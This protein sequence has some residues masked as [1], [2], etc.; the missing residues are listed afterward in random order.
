VLTGQ[1]VGIDDYHHFARLVPTRLGVPEQEELR[2]LAV[3]GVKALDM[4]TCAAHVEFIGTHLGE[5]AARPGGNR[6]RILELAYGMDEIHAYCQVL[7]RQ[8]PEL[9]QERHEAAAVV[10]PFARR[11]GTLRAIRHLDRIVGLPGYLY[12]EVRIQP[13]Q[14]VG[15]SKSGYRAPLY[16]ELMS[17]DANTVRRS[18]DEIASWSDL[19]EVE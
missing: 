7:R 6:P 9:R 10:T 16:V 1:D 5:I 11:N 8:R 14:S 3:A 17:D 19:Y 12:H 2:Q 18:V 13:G 4:T 15:L